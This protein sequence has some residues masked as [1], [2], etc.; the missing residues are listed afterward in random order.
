M[1]FSQSDSHVMLAKGIRTN[2]YTELQWKQKREK[3]SKTTYQYQESLDVDAITRYQARL[4]LLGSCITLFTQ[5]SSYIRV[6]HT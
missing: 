1:L 4:V 5:I 3:K 6:I 2:N